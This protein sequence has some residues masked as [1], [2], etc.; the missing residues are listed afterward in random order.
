MERD[1][2]GVFVTN[3]KAL[4]LVLSFFDDVWDSLKGREDLDS[5][6]GAVSSKL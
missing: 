1:G 4:C 2:T 5:V 6:H 3:R